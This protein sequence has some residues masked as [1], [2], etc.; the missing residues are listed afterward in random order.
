MEIKYY[1]ENPFPDEY[2][3][4]IIT[5]VYNKDFDF[6]YWVWRFK[7]NP[8]ENKSINDTRIGNDYFKLRHFE[9]R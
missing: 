1:S 6:S 4:E 5:S 9:T 7:N 2:M 3:A 8:Y